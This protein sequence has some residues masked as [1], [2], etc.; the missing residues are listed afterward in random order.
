MFLFEQASPQRLL[1]MLSGQ[2]LDDKQ[3]SGLTLIINTTLAA[4]RAQSEEL[5]DV[6]SQLAWING[7][8]IK[9][10]LCGQTPSATMVI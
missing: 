4:L 5:Q 7:N 2:Q 9:E 3:P 1:E 6:L 8:T 10:C